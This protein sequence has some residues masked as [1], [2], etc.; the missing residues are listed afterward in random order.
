MFGQIENTLRIVF[1]GFFCLLSAVPFEGASDKGKP[2]FTEITSVVG[3]DDTSER[4]PSDGTYTLPE[5]MGGGVALFDY[6]NDDDLDLLQIR[7]LLFREQTGET[8]RRAT[9][10]S[11]ERE[12]G[13]FWT[14]FRLFQQQPDG[15]FSDVTDAAGLKRCGLRTRDSHWGYR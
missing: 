2:L 9:E 7:S 10:I 14:H 5:I 11:I 4:W 15:S 6:D 13:L 3:L 8:E 1:I 12:I